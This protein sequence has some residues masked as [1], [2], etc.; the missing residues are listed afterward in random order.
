MKIAIA[1][2]V[3]WMFGELVTVAIRVVRSQPWS[4]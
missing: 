3:G 1:F 2:M 4:R